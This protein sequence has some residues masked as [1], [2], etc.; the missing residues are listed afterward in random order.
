MS[1]YLVVKYWWNKG[2]RYRILDRLYEIPEYPHPDRVEV[3]A[4]TDNLDY[5]R[6]LVAVAKRNGMV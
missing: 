6:D 1:R 4:E 5:A 3:L 2:W